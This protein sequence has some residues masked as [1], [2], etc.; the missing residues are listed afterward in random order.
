[1]KK[2]NVAIIT[3]V[4]H[5]KTTLVDQILKSS[6][7]FRENEDTKRYLENFT[8]PKFTDKM[9]LRTLLSGLY[10]KEISK[11]TEE[12]L[13][14]KLFYYYR[15]PKYQEIFQDIIKSQYEN[16]V[17]LYEAMQF[18][19]YMS[20]NISW[21]S[22]QPEILYLNY[23]EK[24]DFVDY[25]KNLSEKARKLMNQMIE[26]LVPSMKIESMYLSSLRFYKTSPNQKYHLLRGISL[27]EGVVGQVLITDGI[28]T[29][30]SLEKVKNSELYYPNPLSD[31]SYIQFDTCTT[32][33]VE[34]EDSSYVAVQGLESGNLKKLDIYTN[35]IDYQRL[36][37]LREVT[38]QYYHTE[39]DFRDNR[40]YVKRKKIW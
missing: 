39:Q 8:E 6:G 9:F 37:L 24:V 2:R 7:T 10:E 12:Q 11:I 17:N 3:H 18:E 16:K 23:Q 19:K 15:N 40:P 29:M 33:E 21:T 13:S 31:S 20:G 27:T 38:R 1:M 32:R 28:V 14:R 25:Q 30:D 36:Q 22:L 4:D 5:G 34:I 26:E 35:I